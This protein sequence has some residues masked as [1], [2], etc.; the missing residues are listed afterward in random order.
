MLYFKESTLAMA[1]EELA[2]E[3][4]SLSRGSMAILAQDI[5]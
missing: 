5:R 1:R 2:V 3:V 4:A